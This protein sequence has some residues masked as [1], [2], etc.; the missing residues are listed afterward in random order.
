MT[1]ALLSTAALAIEAQAVET[2]SSIQGRVMTE[3]GA[4][5]ANATVII[6][7]VPS[8]SRKVVETDSD[9]SFHSAGLRVGGPYSVTV[10]SSSGNGRQENIFLTLG[11]A[12]D[13]TLTLQATALEEI[14][15]TGSAGSGQIKMGM[16][17]TFDEERR[18]GI[19]ATSRDLHD[20]VR[21]DPLVTVDPTNE[22][23]ISI[24]GSNN[25]FNS[26]T[27]DGVKQNDDFGLNNGGY[28]TQRSPI[29]LDVIDQLS[30][31]AAPFDAQYG[32]F[33]GGNINVVTKSG[34]NEFHGAAW[35]YYRDDS[36]TG[37][38]IDGEEQELDFE[39]KVYGAT[40]GGPIIQDKLFFQVA[41]EKQ[42]STEPFDTGPAGAGFTNDV[43]G[44]TK[45]DVDEIIS[46]ADSVYDYDAGSYEDARSID[47]EDEKI[48]AKIDWNVNDD[49]RAAFTYQ[50]AKGNNIN[51]QNTFGSNYGLIS[52]WYNKTE[53]M[54]SYAL[55]VFSDWT[56]NFSTEVR[57]SYK[58]V[59]TLQ[60]SMTGNDFALME[61]AT[62]GGGSVYIGP[63]YY[64]HA[65][66]LDNN[67]WQIKLAGTYYLDN[68]EITGGYE[69]EMLDVFNLFVPGSKGEYVFDS[70]DDFANQTAASLFYNNAYTNNA[71]DGAAGFGYNIDTLYLQDNWTVNDQLNLMFGLRYERYSS[72]DDP[73]LNQAFVD[74]HGFANNET[75][76]GLDIIMPRFGF[77]YAHD[78]RLTVRG[79]AGLFSGGNP[80]VWISNS[81]SNDGVTIVNTFLPGPLTVADGFNIPQ[82]ALDNVA[83]G[84]ASGDVNYID[85]GFEIPRAWKFNLAV[86]YDLDLGSMGDGWRIT[87]EALYSKT[88]KGTAWVDTCLNQSGTAPDGRPV[89]SSLC[90]GSDQHLGL[91]NSEDG[92]STVF[93]LSLQKEFESGLDFFFSYTHTDSKDINPGTSSTASSN[94]A[95]MAFD[96]P[97]DPKLAT[98]NYEI[99]HKFVLNLNYR[100]EFV[101]NWESQFGLLFTSQSGRPFSYTYD[102]NSTFGNPD[103]YRDSQLIYVPTGANDPLVM[104]DGISQEEFD[105][106]LESSGL[107]KYR[108]E[109]AP[110]NAFNAD[111]VTTV[112]FKFRQEVPGFMEG[113]KGVFTFEI[114]NLTNLINNS[115]GRYQYIPFHYVEPVVSTVIDGDH[116]VYS[117]LN[118]GAGEQDTDTLAS[119][120][121]IRLGLRYEF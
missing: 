69:R 64:R 43:D 112:D 84:E 8:G 20:F 21:V 106:F 42:E 89:Y 100:T 99:E 82:E 93:V 50:R 24:A 105:A 9:G 27:I 1:L 77:N 95:K 7:H 102:G 103:N 36:L 78:D 56:E 58:E 13:V 119:L 75:I 80:N 62:P 18:K 45:A 35:F 81:Y 53:T 16:A 113:H 91:V 39:E 11:E 25:R 5:A 48:F 67:T 118:T 110:R 3:A 22:N 116:Y 57:V 17:S 47:E 88:D 111:W 121:K 2:T 30:V 55:Q 66:Y 34:T 109:I 96:D 86:D 63:D 98:S 85:P 23:A 6:T 40:V 74:L 51:P 60:E 68:H 97:N 115:W 4:P 15:V 52:N 61:I 108:G 38:N 92:E 104:L 71:D 72:G 37:D 26:L 10:E 107:D 33:Q 83:G 19:P 90:D 29:I 12:S 32:G 59:E 41:Y 79:G 31:N 70:I 87:A 94:Y 46:I 117:N 49:H 28:P 101:E 114:Q 54:N 73:R 76:D 14:V 65:N 120:W 44:V